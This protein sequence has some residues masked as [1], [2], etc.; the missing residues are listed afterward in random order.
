MSEEQTRNKHSLTA[1]VCVYTNTPK[2]RPGRPRKPEHLK[3][4]KW[5]SIRLTPRELAELEEASR[6]LRE[7]IG[8][9]FRKGAR[10]YIHR[11]GEGGSRKKGAENR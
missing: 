10:L 4:T 6:G 2:M 5:F 9:I 1:G 7:S 11:K 8:S 3:R